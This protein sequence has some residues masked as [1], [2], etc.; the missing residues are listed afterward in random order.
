MV[1]A[2]IFDLDD[3][4][5]SEK[6]YI[7][8][9]FNHIA[10]IINSRFAI[11]KKQ[12]FDDLMSIFEESPQ[13]VFNRLFDKYKIKYLKE[14]IL[15]LVKEYRE[16]SPNIKFFDDVIPCLMELKSLEIKVG[17]ITDG[18]AITQRKK[19]KAIKADLYFDEIIVTDE[20]GREFWKPHPKSFELMKKK[21]N[22]IFEE[23]VYVGD[24]VLKDF[25][26]ANK[27]GIKT[28]LIKRKDGIYLNLVKTKAH[29]YLAK[30]EINTLH[31][32]TGIINSI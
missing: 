16:H 11:D 3:T 8:S 27:L 5:I 28:V 29:E 24:D 4:L 21:F 19:L 25:I 32:L 12:V 7:K 23:M 26:S 14:D 9:G 30:Y 31:D 22:V 20:L 17:I 13:N 18:Y 2:V 15:N 1:K 10:E 6:E